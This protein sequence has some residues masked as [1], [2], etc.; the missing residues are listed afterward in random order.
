[1]RVLVVDRDLGDTART[2]AALRELGHEVVSAK[3]ELEANRR[4]AAKVPDVVLV[5]AQLPPA[6]AIRFI[7]ELRSR[8]LPHYVYVFLM[9]QGLAET[10]LRAA[11]EAGCDG[12]L[13]KP[14]S[15][16]QL[17]ARLVA[18]H[19]ILELEAELLRRA[20]VDLPAESTRV[21]S[22]AGDE[23]AT[24]LDAVAASDAWQSMQKELKGVV[25]TFL[26]LD[27]A[28]DAPAP[29]TADVAIA[30]GILLSNAE[31]QLEVRLAVAMDAHSAQSL[32]AHV[33]GEDSA[34]LEGDML[35][36]LANM[37][38]G[39]LK[40]SFSQGAFAFTGGLPEPLPPDHLYHYSATCQRQE[41]FV[42]SAQGAS[43]VV[44][45][46]LCSKQNVKVT[47]DTLR[48]GMVLAK[49]VFNARGMLLLGAGTRISSTMA[50]RLK[51]A[52]VPKHPI[53]V[54]P[55]AS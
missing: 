34:E 42:L 41:S 50:E 1:M 20:G 17:A 30:S 45:I 27:V 44:R 4:I 38:M 2:S 25:D 48:E 28:V 29:D 43:I 51:H 18:P 32:T 16:G 7:H 35:S 21:P 11:Y 52:L 39:A 53:E 12:E 37:G 49:D 47:A 24:P 23:P 22:S 40:E 55:G 9:T 33:F 6:D 19:R 36:E 13:H 8:V 26:M 54:A 5:D 10:H 15:A 3:T 46:G 31:H 14:L